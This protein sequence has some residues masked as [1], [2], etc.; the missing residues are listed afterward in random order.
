[1]VY[2]A[3]KPAATAS[4]VSA[5]YGGTTAVRLKPYTGPRIAA[6]PVATTSS[7]KKAAPLAAGFL[8]PT[9]I[10]AGPDNHLYVA[11]YLKNEVYRVSPTDGSKA[12]M[13][14]QGLNG[15][16]GMVWNAARQEW[17]VANYRGNSIS[18]INTNGTATTLASNLHKPYML[19][20][21]EA[22]QMLYI[23]EQETNAIA[24]IKL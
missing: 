1:M 3:A 4:G 16:I 14:R 5:V 15:P 11:N 7:I 20:L 21:D 22:R 2:S 6:G 23:T 13:T 24:K 12:I 9:G 8:G 18:R 19:M 17:Y 10:V